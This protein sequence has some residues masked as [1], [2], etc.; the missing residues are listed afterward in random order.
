MTAKNTVRV[1]GILL[2]VFGAIGIL[3]SLWVAY[4]DLTAGGLFPRTLFGRE[5]PAFIWIGWGMGLLPPVF[6]AAGGVL[7]IISA[8]NPG[9]AKVIIAS[10]VTLI[11]LRL[12]QAIFVTCAFLVSSPHYDAVI[13]LFAAFIGVSAGCILSVCHIKGGRRL[14]KTQLSR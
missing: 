14:R 10:G 8:N 1:S 2:T 11:I 9:R 13:Y 12:L 3:F 4:W 7:G 6:S 5:S